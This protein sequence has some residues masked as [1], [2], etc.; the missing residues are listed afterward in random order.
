LHNHFGGSAKFFEL[1]SRLYK[2]CFYR[3]SFGFCL[4]YFGLVLCD[5][6][7]DALLSAFWGLNTSYLY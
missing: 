3:I 5:A 7:G 2:L 4:R 6:D 1:A